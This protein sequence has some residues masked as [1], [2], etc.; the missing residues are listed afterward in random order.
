MA[1][2]VTITPHHEGKREHAREIVRKLEAH[3][4]RKSVEV[5]DGHRFDFDDD[6]R[7]R[8]AS[9]LSGALDLVAPDWQ[10]HVS[11]GL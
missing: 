6:D 11:M 10:D 4:G 8:N 9:N 2:S 1:T 3:L 5:E 7:E